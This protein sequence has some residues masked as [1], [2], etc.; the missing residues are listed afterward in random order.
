[1]IFVKINISFSKL[2]KGPWE[3]NEQ[4]DFILITTYFASFP[5][6]SLK[7]TFGFPAITGQLYSV[8]IR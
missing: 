7:A 6:V 8:R 5:M 1:M 3:H 4:R 2:A